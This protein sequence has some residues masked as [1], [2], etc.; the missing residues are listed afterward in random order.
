MVLCSS[1]RLCAMPFT[2]HPAVVEQHH[3]FPLSSLADERRDTFGERSGL[4]RD[5]QSI[6]AALSGQQAQWR[7]ESGQTAWFWVMCPQL[8]T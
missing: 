5:V 1:V 2:A 4:N 6:V 7:F 3:F 8:S